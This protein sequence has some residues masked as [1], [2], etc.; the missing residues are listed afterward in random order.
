MGDKF[1]QAMPLALMACLIPR[2]ARDISEA[3]PL[4]FTAYLIPRYARNQ[5]TSNKFTREKLCL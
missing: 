1:K 5:V 4:A 3:M 2:P